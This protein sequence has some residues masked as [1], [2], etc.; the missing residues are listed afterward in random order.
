M[1]TDTFSLMQAHFF[2]ALCDVASPAA[3]L[4]FSA[5]LQLVTEFAPLM[6]THEEREE[7]RR[8]MIKE[9]SK[10]KRK[11]TLSESQSQLSDSMELETDTPISTSKKS[12]PATSMDVEANAA[13]L[14]E[15]QREPTNDI[16]LI[17]RT[18]LKLADMLVSGIAYC[19]APD[20][21]RYMLTDIARY[22]HAN[23]G[24][25]QCNRPQ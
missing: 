4:Q 1:R 5:F 22:L 6:I 11:R 2:N 25:R 8:T 24:K 19:L 18:F 17:A 16:S 10:L 3:S 23:F 12:K 21:N 7:L 9:Q 13:T 15:K 20:T 14:E